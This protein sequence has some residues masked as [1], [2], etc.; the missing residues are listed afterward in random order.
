MAKQMNSK[1]LKFFIRS[2]EAQGCRVEPSTKGYKIYCPN[3]GVLAFHLT[4]SD[5]RGLLNFRSTVR[6]Q[7]LIWPFDQP[8]KK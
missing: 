2:F 5:H 6:A 4:L 3:G 8:G 7:G 1:E